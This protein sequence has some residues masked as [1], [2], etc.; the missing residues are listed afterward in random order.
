MILQK[1][2]TIMPKKIFFFF[3]YIFSYSLIFS[4]EKLHKPVD[5]PLFLS[6]NFG[7]LRS[8]HFHAGLDIKTQGNEGLKVYAVDDGYVYRIKISRNGYGKALYIKHPSGII[9]VYAHLKTFSDKINSY[10]KKKQYKKKSFEIEVFPYKIELPV[11]K[12]EIIAYTGNTGSS[13][14]PHLHFEIRNFKEHPL[15]PAKFGIEIEDTVRPVLRG[16][17]AYSLDSLSHIN[18]AQGRIPLFFYKI[19]DSTY[20]TDSILAYGKI[21]FGID[22]YDRQN[23]SYSQNGIYKAELKVNSTTL[24]EHVMEELNFYTSHY[25]NTFIDYPYYKKKYRRIQKLFV[26]PYNKLEIYTQLVNEGVLNIKN[27]RTYY[28]QII[29][30][31]FNNNSI[32]LKIPV[33]GKKTK[34]TE[35]VKIDKTP[36][37]VIANKNNVFNF[38]KLKIIFPK[39]AAYYNFYLKYKAFKYGFHLGNF[40]VPLQKS[41]IIKYNIKGVSPS[42]K[43]KIYLGRKGRGNKIYYVPSKVENDT[44]IAYTKNFGDYVLAFDSI[45]PKIYPA[46]F[47]PHKNLTDYKR[48]QFDVWEKE[49]GIKNFDGY[50]DGEW[51]LLEYEKKN[52]SLTYDFA[53][54]KL[55]AYKHSLKIIVTDRLGNKGVYKTFFYRKD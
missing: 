8:N 40:E 1:S 26:E 31:D 16:L 2:T 10:I 17:F 30:T 41:M 32:N 51:I 38:K 23:G 18:Q 33:K 35:K 49:S 22:V 3:L 25:I 9:S 15:N 4:Q 50:I 44:L 6:G 45:P 37:Q 36:Y 34:I 27:K 28:V 54:K 29:L 12:G 53:D 21:G 39:N 20:S 47:R 43:K 24:Y 7:E 48:L 19:N 14:G 13:S 52:H 42:W 5:I 46:N 11:K 55:K